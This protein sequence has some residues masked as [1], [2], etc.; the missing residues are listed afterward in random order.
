MSDWN[1]TWR[2]RL[3]HRAMPLALVIGIMILLHRYASDEAAAI[4]QSP[5]LALGL[6]L[7]GGYIGGR[8]S[9]AVR[10]PRVTGYL[11]AGLLLG[12]HV[13]GLLSKE[14]LAAGKAIEG[15]AVALIALTAGGE[16]RLG[17]IRKNARVLSL[18]TTTELFTVLIG[19]GAV[20]LIGRALFP[21]IPDDLATAAVI[22]MVFGA[23][24]VANSP[25]VTIAVIAETRSEGPVARTTLGVTVLKDVA[26]IILFAIALTVAKDAL[27]GGDGASLGGTLLRELGGSIGM[28]LLFGLGISLFLRFVAR[29]VAVFVLAVCL[30]MWGVSSALHLE[31]LLVALT[32]GF[33]VE[34]F[35]S[36]RGEDLIKGIERLSLPVY[37]LFFA[38]AGTKVDLDALALLWPL[39]LLLSAVRGA[40]VFAG[41]RLGAWMADAEPTVQRYAWMGFVSQAGVSL[42]LASIVARNFP[43][44]GDDIQALIV[45]MIAIHEVIG[46]IGFQWALSKA[47]EVG[48][49]VTRG[50][51]DEPQGAHASKAPASA[52]G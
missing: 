29:D 5:T 6:L 28:G 48:K 26:V 46:P 21:F 35:S 20:T 10:L 3:I 14:M 22:A 52:S 1:T 40:C 42:A 13:S 17:W 12:P 31:T 34:N 33:W 47:G 23:I 8:A 16:L 2:H 50:E 24:A 44:W 38:A 9:A 32:A 36:A 27:G 4:A 18:I 25:T 41:T 11:F 15:V 49:A 19:V 43:G 45:A 7:V 30:A 51:P 39:A 37:A